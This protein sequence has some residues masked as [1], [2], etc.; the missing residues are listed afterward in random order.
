MVPGFDAV[1]GPVH[2]TPRRGL[3]TALAIFLLLGTVGCGEPVDQFVTQAAAM[4]EAGDLRAAASRLDAVLEKPFGLDQ[5]L[6]Q[7]ERSSGPA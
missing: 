6:A 2:L 5:F 4:R 1:T 3:A 7:V